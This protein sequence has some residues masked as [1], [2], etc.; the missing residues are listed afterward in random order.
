MIFLEYHFERKIS[1]VCISLS[2]RLNLGIYD[3][4]LN[5]PKMKVIHDSSVNRGHNEVQLK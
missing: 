1:Y 3:L 5:Y 2:F 4:C